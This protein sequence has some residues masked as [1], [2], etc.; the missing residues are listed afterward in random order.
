M[1]DTTEPTPQSHLSFQM[2]DQYLT[3]LNTIWDL[4]QHQDSRAET[5]PSD[6]APDDRGASPA[7]T[8]FQST[9]WRQHLMAL[10][11]AWHVPS[12]LEPAPPTSLVGKL[13][14][15]LK[16]MIF[17]WIQPS[18]DALIHQQNDFNAR[19]VQT[20]NAVV[21]AVNEESVRRLEAQK[22]FNAQ[23]VQTLNGLV[24]MLSE[25]LQHIQDRFPH[26]EDRLQQILP[27]VEEMQLTIWT[28][29]RRKEALEIDEILLNQKLERLLATLRAPETPP[30]EQTECPPLPEP[31]RQEDY[32]YLVFENQYRGPEPVIKQRQEV[33]LPYFEGCANVLDIGCGRGELLELLKEQAIPAYGIDCNQTMVEYCRKKGLQAQHTDVFEHLHALP[34]NTLDG[35][36]M[37]QMIEHCPTPRIKPLLHLCFAKLQ[38]QRYLIIETQNPQSLFA[39]SHFYRDLTHEKPVHPDA[40]RAVLKTVGFQDVHVEYLTPFPPEHILQEVRIPSDVDAAL[41]TH[42]T[43]LNANIRQLNDLLYG[44]LDYAVIAR[45]AAPFS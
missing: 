9:L 25:E 8:H 34:K 27:R 24:D 18:I 40:L 14:F 15:P 12:T 38:Q 28:F 45:K 29:D 33:Y 4:E 23:L 44:Y 16:R 41:R 35:I 19:V 30:G 21:D 32:T 20:C 37:G 2:W 7:A 26:L 5:P 3:R 22:T 10:N 36:F 6:T 31:A 17:R 13:L 42:L 1:S 43:T 11:Q 39:L